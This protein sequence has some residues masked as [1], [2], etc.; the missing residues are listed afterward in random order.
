MS[1]INE[2]SKAIEIL[3]EYS[4]LNPYILKLKKEIIINQD[5]K[6]LTDLNIEYILKNHS[7]NPVQINKT[8]RLTDWYS[9]KLKEKWGC[10]FN[11]E[12]LS[13]K[14]LLRRNFKLLSLHG[15][16]QKMYGT[17]VCVFIQERAYW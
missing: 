14:V 5:I 8:V 13:I 16:I 12:I 15:Q 7:F 10:E 11:P 9:E 17:N 2:K 4:G 1:L 6:Q 3:K